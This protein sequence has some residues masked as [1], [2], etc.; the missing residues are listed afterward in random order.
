M[1]S[2][3]YQIS[4]SPIEDD[5]LTPSSLYDNSSDF[6]DYIGDEYPEKERLE[7]AEC[8]AEILPEL[9]NYVG[10]GT[11]VYKGMNNFLQDWADEIKRQASEMTADNILKDIRLFKL[12]KLTD[13]THRGLYS[14]FYIEDWNG[15]A[16]PA[17]DLI[18][19]LAR[20]KEGTLLYV[21]AVIDF[22]F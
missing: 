2:K 3:I 16:G 4:T 1:H 17:S 8:L 14:R 13:A 19:F 20:K 10:E 22:H 21:G 18:E 6:A 12:S 15:L 7:A 5:F 9:F 11:L